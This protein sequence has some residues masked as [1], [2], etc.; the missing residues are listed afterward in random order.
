MM[1]VVK[2]NKLDEMTS[3]MLVTVINLFRSFQIVYL[4]MLSLNHPAS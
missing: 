4:K 2:S 1:F 3:L